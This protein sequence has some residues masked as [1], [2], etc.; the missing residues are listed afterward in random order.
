MYETTVK[1]TALSTTWTKKVLEQW[2]WRQ[3]AI[4]RLFYVCLCR[5]I[6]LQFLLI[7]ALVSA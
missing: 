6:E 4:G 5:A 7:F 2:M 1:K 3:T